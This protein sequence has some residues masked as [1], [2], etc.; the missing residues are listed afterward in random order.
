MVVFTLLD[1]N[2][3]RRGQ[4]Y[5]AAVEAVRAPIF[6]LIRC[7]KKSTPP[8]C[9]LVRDVSSIKKEGQFRL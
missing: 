2:G 5:G 4:V 1:D 8:G 7:I 6:M 9:D 3:A